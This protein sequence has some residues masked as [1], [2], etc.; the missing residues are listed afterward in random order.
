M[1]VKA[2]V[3]HEDENRWS[4]FLYDKDSCSAAITDYFKPGKPTQFHDDLETV[5]E[6]R[7]SCRTVITSNA[8]DFL[9]YSRDAQK[10]KNLKSCNDCWGLVIVPNKDYAREN[11]LKAADIRHGVRLGDRQVPWKAVAFANLCVVVEKNG[12]SKPRSLADAHFASESSRFLQN[13]NFSR[14]RGGLTETQ[15]AG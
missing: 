6:A 2:A 11:A 14:V 7:D 12:S 13:G 3:F 8:T 1:G 5:I 4:G 9:R 10:N 15:N